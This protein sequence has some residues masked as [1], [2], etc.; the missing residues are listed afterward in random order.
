[1]DNIIFLAPASNSQAANTFAQQQA[2]LITALEPQRL[3]VQNVGFQYTFSPAI[4][5]T[6][7]AD[8]VTVITPTVPAVVGTIQTRDQTQYP[9]MNNI[10]GL[11]TA[12]VILQEQ[13]VTNVALSFRDA[14]N[15]THPM[16]PAQM[17]ALGMAVTNFISST[18]Q[19]K[20]RI[21]N[22]IASLTPQTIGSFDI[23]QG[24][25]S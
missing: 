4:P 1:M 19:A 18:Y 13:G 22:V 9:D 2:A 6:L 21:H 5:A 7:A 12:A 25:T 15:V 10:T 11:T 16:T 14:Q 20:W 24:W 17:I 23:T 8:G 3:I